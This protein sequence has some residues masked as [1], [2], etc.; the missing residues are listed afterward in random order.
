M[1]FS[2]QLKKKFFVYIL[3]TAFK[4]GISLL[5]PA[6][7]PQ[8]HRKRVRRRGTARSYVKCGSY[9]LQQTINSC[10]VNYT[11]YQNILKKKKKIKRREKSMLQK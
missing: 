5:Q 6:L 7:H 11:S 2:K 9:R 1:D 3:F 4:T 8:S 10:K